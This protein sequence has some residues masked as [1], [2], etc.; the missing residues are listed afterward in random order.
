VARVRYS[1]LAEA[2]L[3][4]IATYTL[5]T[6]GEKQAARYLDDIGSLAGKLARNPA[7]GRRCEQFGV[8][9]R[10]MEGGSHVIF[11]REERDDIVVSR[12]LHRHMLPGQHAMNE[13]E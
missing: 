4:D 6:W 8:G 13:E 11:Y 7:L 9:L 2:D 12:I 1:R 10:R 3:L 5:H